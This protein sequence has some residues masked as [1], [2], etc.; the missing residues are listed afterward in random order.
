MVV[1][2]RTN[3]N[4]WHTKRGL[5]PFHKANLAAATPTPLN[6]TASDRVLSQGIPEEEIED[7]Q[8][9]NVNFFLDHCNTKN[10]SQQEDNQIQCWARTL[11]PIRYLNAGP[12]EAKKESRYSTLVVVVMVR[13]YRTHLLLIAELS[14]HIHAHCCHR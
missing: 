2:A 5:H 11:C 3:T 4:Q 6:S 7:I 8:E 12:Q 13:S 9:L 10:F 1:R 14:Q